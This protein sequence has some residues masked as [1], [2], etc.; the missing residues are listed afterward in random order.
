M[1]VDRVWIPSIGELVDVREKL[2]PEMPEMLI[3]L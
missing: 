2:I 1:Q 3:G